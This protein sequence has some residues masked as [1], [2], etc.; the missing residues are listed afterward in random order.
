MGWNDFVYGQNTGCG[1][2]NYS[3]DNSNQYSRQCDGRDLLEGVSKNDF[4]KVFLKSSRPVKG[5][6]AGVSKNVLTLFDCDRNK[7][8]TTDICLDNVVAI[9]TFEPRFDFDDDHHDHEKCD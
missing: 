2:N 1:C 5:F 4:I 3:N 9:K 6:F 7:V 8:S